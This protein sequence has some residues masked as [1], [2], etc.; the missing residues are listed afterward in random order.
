MRRA[1]TAAAVIA[2]MLASACARAPAVRQWGIPVYPGAA[3]IG[4]TNAG[5]SF[6]LYHTSDSFSVVD[7]WYASQLP[8]ATTQHASDQRRQQATFLLADSADGRRTVHI[9]REGAVTAILLTKVD[10]RP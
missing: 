3:A 8:Q 5:A 2:V 6:A 7:R 10:G 1:V 9:E 4:S